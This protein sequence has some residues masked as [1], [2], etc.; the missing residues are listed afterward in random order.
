M[1]NVRHKSMILISGALWA[2][3]GGM[4]LR[5]GLM[6]LQE[7][8]ENFQADA[9][10][11]ASKLVS[12]MGGTQEAV[13]ALIV[14]ALIVGAL[15]GRTVLKKS[16]C[17]VIDRIRT[18]PDPAPLMKMYAPP[19]WLLYLFMMSLGMLMKVTGLPIDIRGFVDTAVGA[20]L[21]N[22]SINYFKAYKAL[23]V[24]S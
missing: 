1:L 16:A 13:L 21:L 24:V 4:L 7:C 14:L 12:V 15:K 19:Y 3:I 9:Y 5:K 11:F 10:P 6:Y 20:A 23:P 18:L 8:S 2:L 17:R 22:G